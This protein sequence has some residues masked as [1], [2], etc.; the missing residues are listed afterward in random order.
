M[1]NVLIIGLF[2][3]L[4]LLSACANNVETPTT[5]TSSGEVTNTAVEPAKICTTEYVPVCGE[6]G[7]TYANQCQAG[8]VR[9]LR[10]GECYESHV[11][12]NAEKQE[13]ACTK[14]YM[15]VCGGDSITYDNRCTA[16]ASGKIRMWVSGICKHSS[17]TPNTLG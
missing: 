6:N 1:R 2:C 10:D 9:I 13:T 15:P 11:C 7:R 4:I 12:T 3:G 16:C 17:G 8:A 5:A 14:E